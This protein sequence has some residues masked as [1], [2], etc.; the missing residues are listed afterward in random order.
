[1][2]CSESS[3]TNA[4]YD[5][6]KYV[7]R[8]LIDSTSLCCRDLVSH[9]YVRCNTNSLIVACRLLEMSG[10]QALETC[11]SGLGLNIKMFDLL[12][13]SG[14]Q[15][16]ALM[17]M[18]ADTKKCLQEANNEV[19][20]SNLCVFRLILIHHL[21]DKENEPLWS[22]VTAIIATTVVVLFVKLNLSKFIIHCHTMEWFPS[23]EHEIKL[24]VNLKKE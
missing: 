2:H 17:K 6:P 19:W 21:Q 4:A 8:R 1:M 23:N 5:C 7:C 3:R 14:K 9:C 13:Q 18:Q 16:R 20:Y 24:Y 10:T 15:K 22:H 11:M 12:A